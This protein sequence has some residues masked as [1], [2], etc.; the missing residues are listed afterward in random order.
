MESNETVFQ[1]PEDGNA[2]LAD[3]IDAIPDNWSDISGTLDAPEKLI[4]SGQ[5][6]RD[7][8][9]DCDRFNNRKITLCGRHL[10]GT[11]STKPDFQA[12]LVDNKL[13]GF[14]TFSETGYDRPEWFVIAKRLA[15]GFAR[16]GYRGL[17]DFSSGVYRET[18]YEHP[19]H[20]SIN[21]VPWE[22]HVAIGKPWRMM[23]PAVVLTWNDKYGGKPELIEPMIKVCQTLA[24]A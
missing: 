14:L 24:S 8:G 22:K 11:P 21:S 12:I 5:A 18:A 9:Y 15:S 7:T 17:L 4:L 16:K 3:L 20:C 1:I 19:A 23:P 6:I 13:P 10:R 2:F